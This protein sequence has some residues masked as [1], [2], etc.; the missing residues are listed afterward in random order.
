MNLKELEMNMFSITF[1]FNKVARSTV[2]PSFLQVTSF[3]S[4]VHIS[5]LLLEKL[6]TFSCGG[7]GNPVCSDS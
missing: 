3:K 7:K 2:G 4:A 6:F 5:I 1:K